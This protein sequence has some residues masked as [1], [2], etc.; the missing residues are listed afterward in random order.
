[1]QEKEELKKQVI[2]LGIILAIVIVIAVVLNINKENNIKN[3]TT[4]IK[5]ET[6]QNTTIQ[7]KEEMMNNLKGLIEQQ[8]KEETLNTSNAKTE[9]TPSGEAIKYLETEYD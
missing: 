1:M 9:S 7:T 3:K 4:S 8:Q 6:S 5:S 2:I